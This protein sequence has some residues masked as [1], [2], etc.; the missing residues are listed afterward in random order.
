MVSQAF[1]VEAVVPLREIAGTVRVIRRRPNLPAINTAATAK[2][3]KITR[4]RKNVARNY[5]HDDKNAFSQLKLI[6]KMV[7]FLL[8][9]LNNSCPFKRYFVLTIL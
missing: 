8:A 3:N 6:F 7:S 9:S 1:L 2:S 4:E 5:Q